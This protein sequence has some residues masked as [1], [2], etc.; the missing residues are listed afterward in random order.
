V[1]QQVTPLASAVV[2]RAA[3]PAAP[4]LVITSSLGPWRTGWDDL[5]EASAL[6]SP[7]A[8]T[9]WLSAVA[10]DEPCFVIVVDG[11]DV[12]GG[13][14]LERREV[15]G[16]TLL[17]MLGAGPLCPD[18]LDVL[19]L[20]GREDDVA[21]T[22]RDWLSRQMPAVIRLDGLVELPNA[23]RLMPE[24]LGRRIIDVAPW[25]ELGDDPFVD[26]CSRNLRSNIRKVKRRLERQGVRYRRRA[27]T[28]VDDA[29]SWLRKLHR[30]QWR[31]SQFLR[32]F[33]RFAAA[34]RAGA[35]RHEVTFHELARGDDVVASV[36]CF[37]VCNRVSFYQTGRI[38]HPDL[39]SSG[40]F[41]LFAALEDAQRRGFHEV[42]FLRGNESYKSGF[43]T[44]ERRLVSL[45]AST[46]AT[47]KAALDCIRAYRKGR[48]RASTV[49]R[50]WRGR[51]R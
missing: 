29:L 43:M 14:A 15:A 27:P 12:I 11:R 13:L 45:E 17:R 44:D 28:D 10:R 31:R 2:A 49:R 16:L 47:G 5:V 42:D 46:G 40:T 19:T 7:F 37:E 36:V 9:W 32:A 20:P 38:L 8:R 1:D 21:G 4:R 25:T 33:T 39:R 48:S 30:E 51:H 22:I 41:L 3:L 26:R 50:R 18:H 35:R 34:A 6:P 24:P 23:E